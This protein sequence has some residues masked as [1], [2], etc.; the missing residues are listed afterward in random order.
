MISPDVLYGLL[1]DRAPG[2]GINEQQWEDICKGCPQLGALLISGIVY[3]CNDFRI[4]D[5][6]KFLA[7][8]EASKLWDERLVRSTRRLVFQHMLKTD[9][10]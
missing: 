8:V 1:T 9:K 3:D 10:L 7:W 4:S 5:D 6:L 2:Y